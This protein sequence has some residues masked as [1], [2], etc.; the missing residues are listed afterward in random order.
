[1][2]V[3]HVKPAPTD[4]DGAIREAEY[5]AYLHYGLTPT[6]KIVSTPTPLGPVDV[7]LMLFGNED[8]TR[9]PI[10]VLHGITSANVFAAPLISG[11]G[12]RYVIAI[13]W[14]GHGL[15]GP[16]ILPPGIAF[17]SYAVSVLRNLLDALDLEE[18]D[19]VGHS[20]GAQFSLYAS[21][22]LPRNIRRVVLLG[23]PG[24][25]LAGAKPNPVMI[26]LAV[27]RLG[28]RL[29]RIQL[30]PAAFAR[31]TEKALGDGAL[32]GLPA[33]LLTAVQLMGRR[34]G[35]PASIASYFRAL[36]R[37]TKVRAAVTVS[38]VELANLRQPALFLWGD[39]DVFMRPSQAAA[40]LAA[41]P[42]AHLVV[43]PGAGHAPWLQF[44]EAVTRAV[45]EHLDAD[46]SG[47]T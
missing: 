30:S 2:N 15:S 22:E 40:H 17:R 20:M 29:L 38:P 21:L 41:M 18:V 3:S 39:E 36:V 43:F 4:L 5:Q 37:R 10:L 23:A 7:R 11:L 46:E 34:D 12:D 45:V 31:N 26:A 8:A 14:P 42:N 25:S 6:E 47:A 1:M 44:Q 28:A 19:L 32:K 33:Q 16:S 35:Y 13:D 9:P 27:P 24:A